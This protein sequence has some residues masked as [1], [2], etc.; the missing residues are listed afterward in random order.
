MRTVAALRAEETL[1]KKF[2]RLVIEAEKVRK[3][4]LKVSVVGGTG[5]VLC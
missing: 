2:K 3:E 5:R 4:S 1:T